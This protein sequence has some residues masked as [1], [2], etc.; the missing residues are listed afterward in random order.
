MIKPLSKYHA[1]TYER[2]FKGWRKALEKF[3]KYVNAEDKEFYTS[4]TDSKEKLQKE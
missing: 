3:V 1:C 4:T 2:R